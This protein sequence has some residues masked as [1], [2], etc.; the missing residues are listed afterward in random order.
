MNVLCI[1]R[2]ALLADHIASLF[3]EAGAHTYPAVGLAEAAELAVQRRPDA[4]LCDYDLLA[5]NSLEPWERDQR[6]ASIPVVAVSLTRRPDEACAFDVNG[7]AGYLYL[8]TLDR[9]A[10]L[11]ALAGLARRRAAADLP[12]ADVEV[13][14]RSFRWPG[15]ADVAA[16][17][18]G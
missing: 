1:G 17:A 5:T 13:D 15:V 7:I 18:N 16:P 6:I 8:P 11:A 2:H 14:A 3:R 9:E 10:A 12:P 4:V